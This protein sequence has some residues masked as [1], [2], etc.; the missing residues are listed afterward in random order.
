MQCLRTYTVQH[1][2][3]LQRIEAQDILYSVVHA[4]PHIVMGRTYVGGPHLG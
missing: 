3:F 2:C 4:M 1:M